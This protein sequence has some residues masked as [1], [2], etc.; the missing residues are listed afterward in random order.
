MHTIIYVDDR[1]QQQAVTVRIAGEVE[2]KIDQIA[3][4]GHYLL[5]VF[6]SKKNNVL[7]KFKSYSA[8]LN[9]LG[10]Y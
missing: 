2:K 10:D 4:Q 7:D 6:D 9:F 1:G 5:A 3:D 8:H